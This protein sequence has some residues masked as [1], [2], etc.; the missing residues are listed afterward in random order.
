MFTVEEIKGYCGIKNTDR[1]GV[2]KGLID[3][4]TDLVFSYCNSL[5]LDKKIIYS[6]E[7]I[8]NRVTKKIAFPA[9]VGFRQGNLI[10]IQETLLNDGLFTISGADEAGITVLEEIETENVSAVITKTSIP[11][12]LSFAVKEAIKQH[13]QPNV[14]SI[15]RQDGTVS[16]L[17]KPIK[18]LAIFDLYRKVRMR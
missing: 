10:R 16:Y 2:I 13:L 11:Q 14:N 5:F 3:G 17:E 7:C 8:F 1:D 12:A 9:D 6:G 15:S 4:Y 18:P